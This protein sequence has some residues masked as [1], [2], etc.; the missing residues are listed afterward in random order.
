MHRPPLD[1][2]DFLQLRVRCGDGLAAVLPLDVQSGF[3]MVNTDDFPHA[4]GDTRLNGRARRQDG[5]VDF[6]QCVLDQAHLISSRVRY[7]DG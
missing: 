5:E 3:V 2:H 7:Y 6:I 1:K 4:V